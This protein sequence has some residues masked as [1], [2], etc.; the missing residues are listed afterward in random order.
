[1]DSLYLVCPHCQA[2]NRV[3]AEKLSAGPHCG[4]CK[5]VLFDGS[6]HNASTADF[7]LFTSRNSTPVVIDFWAPWCG[8]CQ[9]MGPEFAKACAELEPAVRCL[10]INT[11]QENALGGQLNIRSIPTMAIFHGGR[12]IARQAGAMR[13]REIVQWVRAQLER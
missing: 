4:R 8:P 9:M 1:M 7:K 12:E 11:E 10:K 2:V 13:S 5:A 6:P 3:A